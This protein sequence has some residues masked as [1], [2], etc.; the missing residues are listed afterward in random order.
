MPSHYDVL[1]VRT[2]ASVDDI[3]ASYRRLILSLHPDKLAGKGVSQPS[4]GAPVVVQHSLEAVNAAWQV[5]RDAEARQQYDRVLRAD[6]AKASVRPWDSVTLGEMDFEGDCYTYECRCGDFFTLTD[7]EVTHCRS[8][9]SVAYITC[10]TC[11]N[12]LEVGCCIDQPS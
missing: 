11:G 5:L 4:T 1:A 8:T 3:K 9:L 12:V 10:Y 7:I 2:D 6:E